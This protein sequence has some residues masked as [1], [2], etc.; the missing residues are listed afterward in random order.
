MPYI[1]LMLILMFG[2]VAG[3]G[4]FYYKDTQAT[5][6]QL[7]ANNAQLKIVAEDNQR[8]IE[9]LQENVERS[10]ELSNELNSKLQESETRRNQ[11]ISTFRRHDL[12][13]LTLKKPGLIEKRVN[14]G[15]QKA[16]DA[17]ES[18][19]GNPPDDGLRVDETEG[20]DSN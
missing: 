5:I 16:F 18:I 15:T 19:T 17:F 6:R 13:V 1:L 3:G 20:S 10:N 4:Y 12:T 7:E 2:S 8:T 9:T 14:S 11:L